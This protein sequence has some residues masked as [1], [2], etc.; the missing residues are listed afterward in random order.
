MSAATLSLAQKWEVLISADPL[1]HRPLGL[2]PPSTSSIINAHTLIWEIST[3]WPSTSFVL[4]SCLYPNSDMQVLVYGNSVVLMVL[5]STL[6]LY[7]E[8]C[9]SA[10]N[11]KLKAAGDK[12]A[13]APTEQLCSCYPQESEENNWTLSGAQHVATTQN[14]RWCRFTSA[15]CVKRHVVCK[16]MSQK[17]KQYSESMPML[18]E[19]KGPKN[20]QQE[21]RFNC[22][23]NNMSSYKKKTLVCPSVW[24]IKKKE[25]VIKK[26][27]KS[28]DDRTKTGWMDVCISTV[29]WRKNW[30]S[31]GDRSPSLT[32]STNASRGWHYDKRQSKNMGSLSWVES[33]KPTSQAETNR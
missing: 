6:S 26:T 2:Q 27:E 8:I 9:I 20:M 13:E 16:C 14:D 24:W 15:G 25:V 18:L 22:F 30:N 28:R 7:T 5:R 3:H 1:Y 12:P 23:K 33:A 19:T 31:A 10:F 11:L 21:C 17:K 4:V 29:W 32:H